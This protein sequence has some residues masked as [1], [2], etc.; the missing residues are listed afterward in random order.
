MVPIFFTIIIEL[1]VAHYSAAPL[2]MYSN[3]DTLYHYYNREVN[4]LLLSWRVM[5][6]NMLHT[7]S[8]YGS[9]LSVV[10][11]GQGMSAQNA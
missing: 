4:Q 6:I 5:K 9:I 10:A 7:H 11:Q 8:T 1:H 2:S 3:E